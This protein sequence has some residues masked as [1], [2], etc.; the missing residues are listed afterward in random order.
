LASCGTPVDWKVGFGGVS[1]TTS[2]TLGP[3]QTGE[4]C[5]RPL[6]TG[7]LACNATCSPAL[8]F[9]EG[10]AHVGSTSGAECGRIAVEAR[11][12]YTTGSSDETLNAVSPS[13]VVR[14]G[15][16]NRGD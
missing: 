10:N 9:V 1:C 7:D 6:S 14:F 3:G 13:K 15:A 11:T 4:H 12:F 2:L 16:G 5:S 8:T